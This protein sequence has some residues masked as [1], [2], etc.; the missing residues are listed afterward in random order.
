MKVANENSI[1]KVVLMLVLFVFTVRT[2][3]AQDHVVTIK[4]L[5]SVQLPVGNATIKINAKEKLADSTGS[6]STILPKGKYRIVAS[7][8]FNLSE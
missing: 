3:Q 4:V 1:K 6:V 5:D 2:I 7:E 8:K